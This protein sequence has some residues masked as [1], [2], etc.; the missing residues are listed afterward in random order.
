[1]T[2]QS[3][4]LTPDELDSL[5]SGAPGSSLLQH[6]HECAECAQLAAQHTAVIQAVQSLPELSPSEDFVEQVM[7]QVAVPDP[8]AM[9]SLA[10]ARQRMF[11]DSRSRALAASVT[12][13]LIGA[14]AASIVWTLLNRETLASAGSWLGGE[15]T[16]WLW[17]ALREG[18]ANITEQ[19]WFGAARQLLGAPAR[20]ALLSGG[21]M[22]VY[23]AGLFALRKLMAFPAEGAA[24]AE[25]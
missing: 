2:R 8:F 5:L 13:L 14:M 22:L 11:R 23:A 10:T 16:Q 25:A 24:H 17:V 6:T 15:A 12:V 4:H 1:M 20:L 19:P 9:R 3:W 7:F 21:A 18:F